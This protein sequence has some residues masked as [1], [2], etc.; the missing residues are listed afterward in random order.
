MVDTIPS[1]N[2][3][4]ST[5][6]PP[7][8]DTAALPVL[9]TRSLVG[10]V[11]MGLANLVPGISGGTMLLASGIYPRF[12]GAIAEL[13]TFKFRFRSV[14]VLGLV[15]CSALLSIGLLA[16]TV[17]SLVVDHRWI[18][19]SIFIGLTLGGVPVVWQLVKRSKDARH[20]TL[21]PAAVVGFLGMAVLAWYQTQGAGV[22]GE[23]SGFMFMIIAGIVAA[24]AMILPGVS[25]GYLFLVMGV[26]VPVLAG[27]DQVKSAMGAGDLSA[28]TDPLLL[29][30]LPV[31]IGVVV[32]I[33]GVSNVLK[34]LLKHHEKAT[35][36]F[37]LGLL[38]GAVVGLWPFQEGVPPEV[39]DT[40]KGEVLT[41]ETVGL[42]EPED[43][44]T[45]FFRPDRTQVAGA[46]GLVFAGFVATALIAKLG[47]GKSETN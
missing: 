14:F 40:H 24:G 29:V 7:N 3:A 30:V 47:N 16:G 44:P 5:A 1:M 28:M 32:G 22:A 4:D 25:G 27:I 46:I 10:G 23:N 9:A 26:Y 33:V 31:A 38:I 12:I 39:G 15:V 41:V 35:L 21:V 45:A 19:Y 8:V 6:T 34:W 37:L 18:M 17:K 36:G 13:S 42:V 20:G 2:D 43:Y 11:L